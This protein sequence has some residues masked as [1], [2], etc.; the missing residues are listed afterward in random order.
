MRVNTQEAIASRAAARRSKLQAEL[1]RILPLLSQQPGVRRV[2]LFGSMARRETHSRSDLDLVIVQETEK[3]F[4]ERLDEFYLLLVPR[5]GTDMLVYTPAEWEELREN[6]DFVR[7]I[8]IEGRVL[9]D[10]AESERG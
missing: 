2:V 8:S 4:L 9:Y 5:V 7:K 10:A 3:P 6:G 1:D